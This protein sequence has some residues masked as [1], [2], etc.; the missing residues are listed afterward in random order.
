MP[1]WPA[2]STAARRRTG[3]TPTSCPLPSSPSL[4][5]LEFTGRYATYTEADTWYPTWAADGDL[6][7]PWTD[8]SCGGFT[9][10]SKGFL[11]ATGHA[12][13][14]GEDPLNLTVTP[15]GSRFGNPE[16]YEGRYPCGS[17]IKDGVWFYGTYGLDTRPGSLAFWDVLGPFVGFRTSTDLGA[18]WA[19]PPHTPAAPLFGESGRDGA[20]VKMGAPHI[21]D[22]G[23]E[24]EHSPDG[25]AYLVGH[26]ATDPASIC[27]W[28]GG[29]HVYLARVDPTI[30][31][32]HDPAAYEF[33]GGYDAGGA[34][35]WAPG[36]TS[37]RPLIDW[38]AHTGTATITYWPQRRRYLLW[39]TAGGRGIDRMDSWLAEAD[40]IAG[41]Y[42]IVAYLPEF[43]PQAYFLNTP[44]K[45]LSDDGVTGWLCYSGNYTDA[46]GHPEDPDQ[47]VVA[48][49]P[50]STYA[51]VLQ[52]FRLLER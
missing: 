24:L 50:G 13:I 12:R 35:I 45:F 31:A 48:D 44:S 30:E 15:I 36:V 1:T 14:Q 42:R 51:M 28:V 32:M 47:V 27:G 46:W 11:A 2:D 7:S 10:G 8:G 26:G 38:P 33:F 22:F 41:P 3:P 6:Y 20:K 16:P 23:R 34:A 18:T 4:A 29:D 19:D 5:G 52:E 25:K 21:V 39:V 49:P 37:A 17:L 43:G 40:D 9:C